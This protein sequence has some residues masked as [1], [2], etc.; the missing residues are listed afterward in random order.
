[1]PRTD[2]KRRYS[3][4]LTLL[5]FIIAST[6][7]AII[8]I[9]ISTLIIQSARNR[10][11][12]RIAGEEDD[13]RTFVER[14][15]DCD[16][17]IAKNVATCVDDGNSHDASLYT[18]S[19]SPHLVSLTPVTELAV[20]SEVT[21]RA[22]CKKEGL[23]YLFDFTFQKADSV[24]G[25]WK[26]LADTPLICANS[27]GGGGGGGPC[28]GGFSF[29]GG[30]YYGIGYGMSHTYVQ[31][32]SCDSFC[33]SRGG[34]NSTGLTCV[35]CVQIFAALYTGGGPGGC[36]DHAPIAGPASVWGNGSQIAFATNNIAAGTC[37]VGQAV[38]GPGLPPPGFHSWATLGP[39]T[40]V[41]FP[42]QGTP[43]W[44]R[45]GAFVC[46]CNG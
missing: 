7:L 9:A 38:G 25:T 1:M 12:E 31:G 36:I 26:K 37:A 13:L 3:A 20:T 40:A 8:I 24:N 18:A 39:L 2:F 28:V 43:P 10:K 19:Y 4:G 17:L 34:A 29:G 22:R 32:D 45:K 6:I 11:I 44:I 41:K 42:R 33:A 27:G 16:T 5:E 14:A 35:E 30:C 15:F 46:R 23:A 21:I